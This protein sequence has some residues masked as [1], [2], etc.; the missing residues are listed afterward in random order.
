[1]CPI[2]AN[3]VWSGGGQIGFSGSFATAANGG[4]GQ[5]IDASASF[6]ATLS[7]GSRVWVRSV[8]DS[9]TWYP[10]D[11]DTPDNLLIVKPTVIGGG[12]GRFVRNQIASARWTT[13]LS[14]YIDPAN[15]AAN[16]ENSGIDAAHPLKTGMELYR[17]TKTLELGAGIINI[18]IISDISLPDALMLDVST[19]GSTTLLVHGSATP[20][21]GKTVLYSGTITAK[22]DQAQA[23]N[24]R[25]QMTDAGVPT[26]T[27]AG[28]G[29]ISNTASPN[30]RIRFTSGARTGCVCWPQKD[31]AAGKVFISAIINVVPYLTAAYAA[32]A[33]RQ[34]LAGGETFSLEALVQVQ[35]MDLR[36]R[37]RENLTAN[38]FAVVSTIES[39][40]FTGS[41]GPAL[42]GGANYAVVGCCR[43]SDGGV[44]SRED[45]HIGIN[46]V[47]CHSSGFDF[48][49][50]RTV[51]CYGCHLTGPV[52]IFPEA[53][54]F[55]SVFLS[56]IAQGC[57]V[58]RA[59]NGG[60]A[61][62]GCCA[63]FDSPSSAFIAIGN[64]SKV[65]YEN[66]A[67]TTDSP[68]LWGNGNAKYGVD[69]RPGA[70]F[71]MTPGNA[72]PVC[73]GTGGDFRLEGNAQARAFDETTGAYTALRNS[74]WANFAATV[75]AGGFG[76]NAHNATANS[77]M[78]TELTS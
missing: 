43:V 37:D 12:A 26:G 51:S 74:T 11:T 31:N 49:G 62:G 35:C 9:Y 40:C 38:P 63:A 41:A 27:W 8:R 23:T 52:T 69:V 6:L 24:V 19:N 78:I 15:V 28:A 2:G 7:E 60:K 67:G 47:A 3:L 58:L 32:T 64:G 61:S 17:R 55:V 44:T 4:A 16:D 25:A 70:T 39:I 48:H 30:K 5:L 54:G 72:N 45:A 18:Y 53:A 77:H 36:I 76:G 14:W 65:W 42:R 29:F 34:N 73:T 66:D 57:P 56:T 1:M 71:E 33:T 68:L 13:Q 20:G 10:L 21:N 75:A 59:A 22:T 50:G 46:F